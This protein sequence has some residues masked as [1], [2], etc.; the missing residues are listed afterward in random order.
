MSELILQVGLEEICQTLGID[1]EI[2]PIKP[3]DSTSGFEFYDSYGEVMAQSKKT[4]LNY[5][6]IDLTLLIDHLFVLFEIRLNANARQNK[7]DITRVMKPIQQYSRERLGN[8][9]CGYVFVAC[10][11]HANPS[12][13]RWHDFI[14][15][16]GLLVPFYA[17]REKFLE[18]V[19]STIME[20]GLHEYFTTYEPHD[21]NIITSI[22]K[23]TGRVNWILPG[24][25]D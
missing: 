23:K 15:A 10:P 16:G 3:G 22:H 6:G 25:I 1:A 2:N 11:S 17:D 12:F 20:Y 14:E 4:R 13:G 5:S 21:L 9:P 7:K 8:I 24:N 19:F 18:D